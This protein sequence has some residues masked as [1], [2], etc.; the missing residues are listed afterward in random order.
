MID[1]I[2]LRPVV[3]T[4]RRVALFVGTAL[5]LI[6]HGP[7]LLALE[8]SREQVLQIALTYLV[9]YAVSTYS[10]IKMPKNQSVRI[11]NPKP[12]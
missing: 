8:M 4:A 3:L 9:P 6:N 12:R 5:A 1:Y 10:S 11:L 7:A 2:F